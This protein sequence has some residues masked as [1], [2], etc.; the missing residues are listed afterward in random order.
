MESLISQMVGKTVDIAFGATAS[1]RGDVIEVVDGVLFLRDEEKRLLYVAIERIAAVW[2]VSDSQ[3][4][5]GFI[6]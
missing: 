1:V 3:T 5:P 4:R 6:G 2:E